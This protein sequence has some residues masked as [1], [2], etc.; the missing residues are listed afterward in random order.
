MPIDPQIEILPRQLAAEGGPAPESRTVAENR[1][2]GRA[3]AAPASA[4]EPVAD[5]L[6]T[7]VPAGDREIPIRIYRPGTGRRTAARDA[8]LPRRR[9]GLRRPG[10]PGPHRLHRRRPLRRDRGFRRLPV[11]ARAPLP[12]RHRRR[13]RRPDL[14]RGQRRRLRRRRR[15]HRRVRRKRRR[16]PRRDS[17]TGSPTPRGTAHHAPGARLPGP[18]PIR[19]QPLD[20]RVH[21]RTD[22]LPFLPRMVLGVLP[23]QPGPGCRPAGLSRAIRR[24]GRTPTRRHRHCRA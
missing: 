5:V 24:T 12:G 22:P 15:T 4:A 19:R 14:G 16:Q 3:F 23:R 20:V 1:A 11:G 7:T 2:A 17:R 21:D 8:L 13:V 10:H 6:D 9:M 18:R